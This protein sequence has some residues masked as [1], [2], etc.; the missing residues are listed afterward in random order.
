MAA[1]RWSVPVSAAMP[2]PTA[3]SSLNGLA[4]SARTRPSSQTQMA[5]KMAWFISR[6]TVGLA[7]R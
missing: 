2:W 5:S 1:S 3:A 4:N 6:L 7:R